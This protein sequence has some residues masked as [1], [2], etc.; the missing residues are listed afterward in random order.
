MAKGKIPVAVQ[1]YSVRKDCAADLAGTLKAIAKMGYD[2]VE[3]AGFYNHGAAD[4]RKMLEDAGLKAAGAHVGLALLE[5]DEIEKTIEFHR[6]LVNSH[7]IVPGIP[8]ERRKTISDWKKVAEK[9][10]AIAERLRKENMQTGYHNHMVEFAPME[11]QIP[12]DVFFGIASSPDII[13]QMDTGNCL[14][15]GADPV[16]FMEKYPGRLTSVHLKEYSKTNGK[17][18]IGEGEVRWNDVF[19]ICEG[20]G[21]T[22]WYIVEQESYAYPPMEC[23]KKCREKLREMGR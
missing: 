20:P 22:K 4:V 6:T 13:V 19:R 8:E 16:S 11:G 17:A 18:I 1:L 10:N 5:G 9:L 21:K 7:L 3:F 2:G 23:I 14:H 12:W 15:G